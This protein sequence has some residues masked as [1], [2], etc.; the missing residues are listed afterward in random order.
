MPS[1]QI[2]GLT[3]RLKPTDEKEWDLLKDYPASI[4]DYLINADIVDK[5]DLTD[6]PSETKFSMSVNDN[7]DNI[8]A[9]KAEDEL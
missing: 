8:D 4:G 5:H 3:S 2:A 1:L 9:I 7:Y 6:N